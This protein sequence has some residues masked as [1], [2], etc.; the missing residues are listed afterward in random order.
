MPPDSSLVEFLA[1]APLFL[2]PWWLEMVAPGAWDY[3]VAKRGEEIAAAM[4]YTSKVRGGWRI[5]E[6]PEFTPMLG[7]WLRRSTA[8]YANRLG[9]EKDLMM[10]LIDGLPKFALFQQRFHHG[11]T[12]WLPFHWRGFQQTTHYTYRIEDTR[13]LERLWGETRDNVRTDIK[14]ARKSVTVE[15][16]DDFSHVVR[17]QELTLARQ[18]LKNPHTEAAMRHFGAVCAEH[19]AGKIF[20]ARDAQGRVHA[21]VYLLVDAR[22]VYYYTGG[23]DPEL[24]N[25]GAASL[26]VWRAIELASALGRAFDFEGSMLEPVERFFRSFGAVQTPHFEIRKVNSRAAA[27]AKA[28]LGKVRGRM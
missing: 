4:P 6:M 7:P 27:A 26:L 25:S 13:D 21:S 5:I 17:M 24:R 28:L 8:K 1:E 9:E 19:G 14:K 2:Q 12:N 3:A 10:G 16:T 15:E 20:I 23:G 18:G 11:V 22:T